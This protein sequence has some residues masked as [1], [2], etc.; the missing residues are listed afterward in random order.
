M[1]KVLFALSLIAVVAFAANATEDATTPGVAQANE[2]S[3]PILFEIPLA[4][5]DYC[6]GVGYDDDNFWVSAGDQ[7]TGT[8]MFYIFDEY[9]NLLTELPQGGGASG[10]GHRDMCWDGQ[11]MFGSFSTM[12]DAFDGAYGFAG[13]FVGYHNPN[14]VQAFNG[15]YHFTA[16]FSDPLVRAEWDGMFG[17]APTW[18]VLGVFD[19]AYGGAYDYIEDC[20]W[21]S[22]ANY[23]GDLYQCTTDGF[24]LNVWTCLP[25]YDIQGGCTMACTEQF[26]YILCV[27]QQS[28]PDT[29]SFYDLGHGPSP[30]EEGSWGSIKAM[31]R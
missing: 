31:F 6:V 7:A 15:Q 24:L 20:L 10:W 19:A 21:I 29:L 30:T 17:S 25:E 14:R 1:K 9:G 12:I 26:G 5:N 16:N 3:F 2:G 27:L 18:T 4:M 8:A 28:S 11:Y 13:F 22:T 23:T